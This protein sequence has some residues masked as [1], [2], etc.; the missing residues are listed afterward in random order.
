M[1]ATCRRALELGLPGLAFTEH[2]DFVQVHEG[3]RQL[4]VQGYLESVARCAAIFPELR[5]LS[6]VELG[7]PHR[8]P[9]RAAQVLAAGPLDRILGS[10]HCLELE[11]RLCD[12][13]QPGILIPSRAH[14]V[15]SAYL[16]EVLL[17]ARSDQPFEVLAHLD[18]PKR[19]WPHAQS[20]FSSSAFEERYRGILRELAARGSLLEVNTTRGADPR[21]G[22]CPGPEVLRWWRE[23]GGDGLCFGSDTHEPARLAAGFALAGQAAEAA[24][25]RFAADPGGIWRR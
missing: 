20:E 14:E 8:H 21:R 24:G 9:E 5:V 25:F 16:D 13:S 3:Q 12:M 2:A 19:Y 4:D 22:L 6:G 1:E 10:V 23:E 11:G 18:Y 17:L 7:E 15:F